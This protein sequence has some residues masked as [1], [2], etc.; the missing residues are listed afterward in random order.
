MRVVS[1]A[2]LFWVFV[3]VL[4]PLFLGI[5]LE[6]VHQIDA[7]DIGGR[8]VLFTIVE[9]SILVLF[10]GALWTISN[11]LAG[12]ISTTQSKPLRVLVFILFQMSAVAVVFAAYP[13]GAVIS[14]PLL[15]VNVFQSFVGVLAFIAVLSI[16]V[17]VLKKSKI[18]PVPMALAVTLLT[19][20][21]FGLL[22]V[23]GDG[24]STD[25]PSVV[26]IGIDSLRSDSVGALDT[27]RVQRLLGSAQCYD[28]AFTPIARTHGSLT[29]ILSGRPPVEHGVRFNLQRVQLQ[30]NDFLPGKF[31]LLG[32]RTVF[33]MDERR[34][35]SIDEQYGFDTTI[36]PSP[37]IDEF[38]LPLIFSNPIS[39]FIGLLPFADHIMP[40]RTINRADARNYVPSRF[41]DTV[42]RDLADERSKPLFL[43]LHLTLPHYPIYW[44]ERFRDESDVAANYR[45]SI[46]RASQQLSRILTFLEESGR[47]ENS[48][49]VF[50]SD[51]GES[52]DARR[53]NL[54]YLDNVET[55]TS[56]GHGTNV[57]SEA[58]YRV[59]LCFQAYSNGRALL[60]SENISGLRSTVQIRGFIEQLLGTFDSEEE[61]VSEL[62]IPE[63][64]YV[65]IES[66]R[67]S[68]ALLAEVINEQQIARENLDN[69]VVREG[70]VEFN[71]GV[72]EAQM[73]AK[74]FAVVGK[75]F[76]ISTLNR[77]ECWWVLDRDTGQLLSCVSREEAE[78]RVGGLI[79]IY[80]QLND[81]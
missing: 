79:Q 12:A 5:P 14:L 41:T 74:K 21:A 37:G 24:G 68:P 70:R 20:G 50:Y 46:S 60:Q 71:E 63:L 39:E 51:H 10:L 56:Y 78:S 66:S 57:L 32:Y 11:F 47:L 16:T 23:K 28:D 72:L 62:Q 7:S 18:A 76:T 75:R 36:G 58:Q 33:A 6:V 43:K 13:R 15:D 34:F 80:E 54:G 31:Q 81:Q 29:T 61:N 48:I 19:F 22:F 73:Q 67:V 9:L 40:Y 26:L 42:I 69:F 38:V 25:R 35:S 30:S 4:Q 49:V 2:A 53:I 45:T 3:G 59:P 52:F 8:I 1:S 65:A 27:Q 44:R 77:N 64:S 17:K 55:D